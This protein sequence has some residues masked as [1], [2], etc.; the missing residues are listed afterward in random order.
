MDGKGRLLQF[1]AVEEAPGAWRVFH[2]MGVTKSVLRELGL[3]R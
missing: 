3:G 2:A 1:I